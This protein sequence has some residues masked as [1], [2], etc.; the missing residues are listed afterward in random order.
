MN[1]Y[2]CGRVYMRGSWFTSYPPSLEAGHGVYKDVNPVVANT[3][4]GFRTSLLTRTLRPQ[5]P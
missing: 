1:L 3:T 4:G 2:T 5:C